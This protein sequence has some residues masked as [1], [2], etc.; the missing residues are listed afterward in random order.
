VQRG[1]EATAGEAREEL[2]YS[3]MS[4]GM[5]AEV[6]G[7][8]GRS[9]DEGAMRGFWRQWARAIGERPVDI[10]TPPPPRPEPRP[11]PSKRPHGLDEILA[12]LEAPA[13][14]TEG[15]QVSAR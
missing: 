8:R 13:P 11:L 14:A 1:I 4:R 9:I 7:V 3:D 10:G 2:D 15:E 12:G 5:T 6:E